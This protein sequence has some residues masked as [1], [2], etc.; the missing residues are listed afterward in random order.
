MPLAGNGL[1][2]FSP[3][4]WPGFPVDG[5]PQIVALCCKLDGRILIQNWMYESG[6]EFCRELNMMGANIFICDPQRVIVSGPTSLK[7]SEVFPPDV[8][9]AIMA[10]FLLSLSEKVTTIIHGTHFLLRRYP[11][12]INI[13]QK[14]GAK[15]E[16]LEK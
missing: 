2:K 13:Y 11:D 15:I 5:L 6:L 14:L 7:N 9:Q 10:I 3:R 1:P 16:V 8:I 12:I 4:P